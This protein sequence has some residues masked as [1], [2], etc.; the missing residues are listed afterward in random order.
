MKGVSGAML[1][2]IVVIIIGIIAI[3][4]LWLFVFEGS[5][6]ISEE[7]GN[8]IDTFKDMMCG[9]VGPLGFLLGC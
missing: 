6:T 3:A 8:L 2:I 7:F 9:I 4:L 5:D 1:W